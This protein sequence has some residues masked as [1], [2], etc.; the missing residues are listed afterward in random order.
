MFAFRRAATV[1]RV[2]TRQHPKLASKAPSTKIDIMTDIPMIEK[3]LDQAKIRRQQVCRAL[4][5]TSRANWT[6]KHYRLTA[7]RFR[8]LIEALEKRLHTLKG[9]MKYPYLVPMDLPEFHHR[10]PHIQAVTV[11]PQVQRE[12]DTLQKNEEMYYKLKGTRY[13]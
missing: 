9:T 5:R 12:A 4:A 2:T 7:K 8:N 3:Y 11:V 6:Y 1:L 13:H 10:N